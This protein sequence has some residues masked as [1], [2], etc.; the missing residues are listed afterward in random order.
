MFKRILKNYAQMIV[1]HAQV[2][3][4]HDVLIT[5][6]NGVIIA[7][8]DRN[9]L[10]KLHSHSISVIKKATPEAIYQ[11][12]ASRYGVLEGICL[13]IIVENDIIGTVG[14]TGNPDDVS[15]YGRLVQKEAELFVREKSLQ[16]VSCIRENAIAN[17]IGHIINQTHKKHNK[18][19]FISQAQFLGYDLNKVIPVIV[20]LKKNK[21]VTQTVDSYHTDPEMD[22][23]ILKLLRQI[24]DEKNLVA[25]YSANKYLILLDTRNLTAHELDK[26]IIDKFKLFYDKISDMD[27]SVFWGVGFASDDIDTISSSIDSA[28]RALKIGKLFRPGECVHNIENFLLEDALMSLSTP[29]ATRYVNKTLEKLYN[30]PGWTH[31]LD[32]TLQEW[33][34]APFDV[35]G[36]AKKLAIHKNSVYYRLD[37]INKISGV[38]LHDHQDILRLRVSL[39]IKKLF[40]NLT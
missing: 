10:G 39:L 38:N 37:K 24:F 35:S 12:E 33:L 31:E 8:K 28:L 5:D 19:N 20:D 15:Q 29:F 11:E 22:I 7:V 21:R 32:A 16:E 34:I 2:I 9:R 17:L 27:I 3:I 23:V 1:E 36:I 26:L 14:I 40:E 13:P 6:R 30:S 25:T 4:G 18:S